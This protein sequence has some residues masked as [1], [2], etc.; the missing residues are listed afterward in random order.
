MFL[1]LD[2]KDFAKIAVI[3][4]TERKIKFGSVIDYVKYFSEE[5]INK[6]ILAL[7][8]MKND[9]YSVLNYVA[10]FANKIVPM[11][12]SENTDIDSLKYIIEKYR[13]SVIIGDKEKLNQLGYFAQ[14]KINSEKFIEKKDNA[15]E[16]GYYFVNTGLDSF[17]IYF[18]LSILL[19]TSGSTG[20]PKFVRHNYR[21]IEYQAEK[22]SKFF[23][24]DGSERPLLN[25][26]V[27][28]TYGLS[29]LN[30]YLY[31]GATVLL[32]ND[33][34]TNKSFWDFFKTY[35]ATSITGVPYTFETL[36]R[37]R[38]FGMNL[39]SL[40]MLSQGGGKLSP[41]IQKEFAEF[42]EAKGGRYYATYGASEG[43][44]RMSFLPYNL[45]I[46]KC[47]SI[48]KT[49]GK[50]KM[51]L[52]NSNEAVITKPYEIGEL[53]F[54]GENVTLGYAESGSDL[55]KGDERHGILATGD[56][57]YFDEDGYF[58]ISGRKK[59]F[60]KL[61][62][63]RV[64]LDECELMIKNK[65]SVDCA[66]IGNDNKLYVCIESQNY[67]NEIKQYLLEKTNLYSSAVEVKL[68]K[69]IPKNEAGKTL[70]AKLNEL[71]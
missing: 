63:Y 66:C 25:L 60:L 51:Y 39:P 56:M 17:E 20:S 33:S 49:F 62:G 22:I 30:S 65:F 14:I 18:D 68:I 47:G 57:G 40:K 13:P 12:V 15:S 52:K 16:D 67:Q 48:G 69:S 71:I 50:D 55:I 4:N 41:N 34:F 45:A 3:D 11:L 10:C 1:N 59:R 2:K 35:E 53:Y 7:L 42:I 58:Y 64:S 61:Y 37:L 23:E 32:S 6:R 36:K 21:N 54:E 5:V 38:F 19:T 43:S 29:V 8:L 46:K 26:P 44:A 9:V 31:A 24:M 28:Y 70:Y 27:V